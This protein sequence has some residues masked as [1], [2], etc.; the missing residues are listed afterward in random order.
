MSVTSWQVAAILKGPA[1]KYIG[2]RAMELP[3]RAR[4]RKD[5]LPPRCGPAEGKGNPPQFN[6]PNSRL[7]RSS[8]FRDIGSLEASTR[9]TVSSISWR[10]FASL[11][12]F[13]S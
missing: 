11:R 6:T 13:R 1:K 7:P 10:V 5:N 3:V 2:H 9:R 12:R 4:H 8:V